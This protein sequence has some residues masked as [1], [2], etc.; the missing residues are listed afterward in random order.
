MTKQ[1]IG[2]RRAAFDLSQS[3][4]GAIL[5]VEMACMTFSLACDMSNSRNSEGM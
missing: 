4:A 3:I 5:V 2:G 1:L